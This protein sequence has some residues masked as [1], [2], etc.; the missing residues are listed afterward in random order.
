MKIL[1][2]F[3]EVRP[4]AASGGLSDVAGSLPKAIRSRQH[5]C[6]VVM[7]LYG[8]IKQEYRSLMRLIAEFQVPLSWRNQYC[9][10]YE[11]T[12]NGV[13]YYFLDN[14]YYFKRDDKQLYGYYDDGERFAFFSKAVLEMLKYIDYQPDIIHCNDWETALIPVFLNVSYRGND[15]IYDRIKTVFTIHNIQYQ[16]QFP[17]D[18][19][20][21]VLGIPWYSAS[22][23]DYNGCVNYMKGAI[24]TSDMVT[25]VSPTYAQEI[26]NPWFSYGLDPLLRE[27]QYKLAGIINGIDMTVNNP[28][29]DPAMYHNFSVKTLENRRENKRELQKAMGLEQND[30]MLIGIVTRLA[31]HK[32]L[33]LVKYIFDEMMSKGGIQVVVLGS[34]DRD[35]EDFFQN[36]ERKYPGKVKTTIGFIPDLAQKIYGSVD[37]F[38]MPSKSEPCG[39]AQMIA[40]R[41]GAIPLVRETGG[42]K[43][44]IQD[45]GG[46]NGNGFTF[47]SYNAHDMLGSILRAKEYYH[48]ENWQKAVE[49]AMYCDF[50]WGKSA[51]EYIKLYK[52][53]LGA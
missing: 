52:K 29:T 38:L 43:D 20:W 12:Y 28:E 49:H 36:M 32:G 10:V 42:L 23:L 19:S 16:G 11:A 39:L 51:M 26:M 53:V 4:F 33:D 21:D 7:P 13:K 27:R 41:Y 1:F 24:E 14:E 46:E 40:L 44:T 8:S 47:Q 50:S 18:I 6:R 37:L 31:S 2:A 30:D 3:S 5:A 17:N 34:G 15:E 35:L 9:G 48:T 45:L 22:I 25:T